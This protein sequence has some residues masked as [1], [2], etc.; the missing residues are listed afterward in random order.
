MK[1]ELTDYK[2]P[3][4][5]LY[6]FESELAKFTGA[7]GVIV[8]DSCEHA[9]ELGLRYKKPKMYATIP[10]QT[11]FAIPMILKALEIEYMYSEDKWENE[12]RIQGSSVYVSAK[13]LAKDMFQLENPNQ[14]KI[15]CVSFAE[16]SAL[17][18]GGGGAILTNDKKAYEWLKLAANGGRDLT[19]G[20]WEDQK[21]F[22]VGYHYGMRP[23]DAIVGLDMLANNEIADVQEKYNNYPELTDMLIE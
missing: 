10:P 20:N 4:A 17:N 16:G 14:K 18:L 5:A 9:I 7:T 6:E 8:T 1:K 22:T 11:P 15:V 21:K 12:F 19:I 2:T 13:H 3:A 23:A